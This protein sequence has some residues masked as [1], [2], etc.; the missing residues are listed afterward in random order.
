MTE[1]AFKAVVFV[2]LFFGVLVYGVYLIWPEGKSSKEADADRSY[3]EAEAANSIAVK[4]QGFNRALK[5]YLE[6]KDEAKGINESSKLDYNIANA[7]FQLGEYPQAV[8]YYYKALTFNPRN[9]KARYNLSIALEK[10]G[11]PEPKRAP[12]WQRPFLPYEYLSKTESYQLFTL[13]FFLAFLS[14][15]VY[16][17]SKRLSYGLFAACFAFFSLFLI[18]YLAWQELIAYPQAVV[19]RSTLLYSEADE[20]YAQIDKDLIRAGSKVLVLNS[21]KQ[22]S[23][24]QV[25]GPDDKIGFLP[26]KSIEFI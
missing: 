1:A 8:L 24:L 11:L 23:W 2:C 12:W 3:L 16:L 15:L 17:Y 5:L 26:E 13:L 4:E 22:G 25:A 6:V 10:L 7:F 14:A 9:A 21:L 18:C 20:Q 19:V